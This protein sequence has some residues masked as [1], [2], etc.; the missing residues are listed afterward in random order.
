MKKEKD[1]IH[2]D[3]EIQMKEL[4]D[5]LRRV[6]KKKEEVQE[7]Y[8]QIEDL[9]RQRRAVEEEVSKKAKQ[10]NELREKEISMYKM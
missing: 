3:M 1:N 5:T 8:N 10:A 6:A 9:I 4:K 7:M 2:Q